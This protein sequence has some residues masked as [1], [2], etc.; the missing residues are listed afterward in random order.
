MVNATIV[1][2]LHGSLCD[3]NEL[4]GHGMSG[5]MHNIGSRYVIMS[6]V[7]TH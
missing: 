5:L 3:G 1:K 7:E 2:A 4:E 6:L